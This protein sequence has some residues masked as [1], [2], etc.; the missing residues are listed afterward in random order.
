MSAPASPGRLAVAG[1]TLAAAAAFVA[2]DLAASEPID[3]FAAPPPAAF[4]SGLAAGGAHC[5]APTATAPE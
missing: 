2:I 1:L 4:G 3:P 5:A